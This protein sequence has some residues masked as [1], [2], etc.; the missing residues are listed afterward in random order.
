MEARSDTSS[1]PT[2]MSTQVPST[3]STSQEGA[4]EP[5]SAPS[6]GSRKRRR[7]GRGIPS[8]SNTSGRAR[9]RHVR[10]RTGRHRPKGAWDRPRRSGSR[11]ARGPYAPPWKGT[12]RDSR[13]GAVRPCREHMHRA[14]PA[15]VPGLPTRGRL[16]RPRAASGRRVRRPGDPGQ[17]GPDETTAGRRRATGLVDLPPGVSPRRRTDRGSTVYAAWRPLRPP[18]RASPSGPRGRSGPG[19]WLDPSGCVHRTPCRPRYRR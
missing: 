18:S 1:H 3:N 14:P 5:G 19:G 12:E 10:G 4:D 13:L 11:G 17:T 15:L 16:A 8:R 7:S 9:P 2:N 6:L